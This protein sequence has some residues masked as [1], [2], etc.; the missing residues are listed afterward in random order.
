MLPWASHCS[1]LSF[2]FSS[3]GVTASTSQGCHKN[4]IKDSPVLHG[5]QP[6]A[7]RS[8]HCYLDLWCFL[9]LS[10]LEKAVHVGLPGPESHTSACCLIGKRRKKYKTQAYWE[11][12]NRTFFPHNHINYQR[13]KQYVTK[14]QSSGGFF[15]LFLFFFF[16]PHPSLPYS[17]FPGSPWVALGLRRT[18]G[19]GPSGSWP[20]TSRPCPTP[21]GPGAAWRRRSSCWRGLAP[22]RWSGATCPR[23]LRST[24]GRRWP[25]PPA[26][27]GCSGSAG[28][29]WK[30]TAQEKSRHGLESRLQKSASWMGVLGGQ[31]RAQALGA[32]CRLGWRVGLHGVGYG[33]CHLCLYLWATASLGLLGGPLVKTPPSNAGGMGLIPSQRTKVPHSVGRAKK[34]KD[35]YCFLHIV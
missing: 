35:D 6:L 23:T 28:V 11:Y 26:A 15:C 31:W 33:P 29:C 32:P 18:G 16:A 19:P 10:A 24:A 5:G 30:R 7:Y 14:I 34:K 22:V 27:K 1:S 2:C 12:K 20:S 9:I 4:G 17:Y 3:I 13:K 8:Y 21:G 25:R